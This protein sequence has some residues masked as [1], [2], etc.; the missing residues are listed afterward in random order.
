MKNRNTT[1]ANSASDCM[2][3]ISATVTPTAGAPAIRNGI[4]PPI[5]V[6]S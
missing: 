4:R 1:M 5:R 2:N 6:R 3:P